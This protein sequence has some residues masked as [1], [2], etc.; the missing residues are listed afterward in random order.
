MIKIPNKHSSVFDKKKKK[1]KVS[2]GRIF[3]NKCDN[4][5]QHVI[6]SSCLEISS[7]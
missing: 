7:E 2:N 1:K 3:W 6:A 4:R 5:V